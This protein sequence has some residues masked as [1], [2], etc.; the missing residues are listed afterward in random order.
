M[1]VELVRMRMFCLFAMNVTFTLV[2]SIAT[3]CLTDF[4]QVTGSVS[5]AGNRG[6]A[7]G[8]GVAEWD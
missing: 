6:E 7:G 5:I 1:S 8:G 2:M 3:P 4:Q